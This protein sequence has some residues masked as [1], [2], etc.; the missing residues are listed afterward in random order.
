MH[1]ICT[2]DEASQE[3]VEEM[4]SRIETL[5]Q[6]DLPEIEAE[7]EKIE[8]LIRENDAEKHL[9]KEKIREKF[10][11]MKE[12]L[13]DMARKEYNKMDKKFKSRA[14]KLISTLQK[15]ERA[16]DQKKK[17]IEIYTQNL[18][19][20]SKIEMKSCLVENPLL[21]LQ[22]PLIEKGDIPPSVTFKVINDTLRYAI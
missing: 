10:D 15:V 7:K 4:T 11:N 20:A 8:T 2:I 21:T 9:Y 12:Q 3:A 6:K 18:S 5:Q 17:L 14:D 19:A 13:D 16:E 22:S 1:S